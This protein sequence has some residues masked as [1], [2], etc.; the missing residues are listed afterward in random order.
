MRA[1]VLTAPQTIELTT[2]DT[3]EPGP[4]EV[5]VRMRALGLCGSDMGV[6][7]GE[8]PVPS[9]PWVM[10]HEGGGEVVSVGAGVD[11]ARIGQ[12]VVIEPN[13]P[14]LECEACAAGITSVCQNRV[15]VGINAPGLLS[16][17]VAVPTQFAHRLP[18]GMPQEALAVLEPLAVARAAVAMADV[19]AGEHVLVAGAGSQGLMVVQLLRSQGAVPWVMELDPGRLQHAAELG[20]GSAADAAAPAKFAHV[21]DAVGS[22]GLWKALLPK[23]SA[24]TTITV[25][26]MS[27]EPLPVTTKQITRGRMT[28]QGTII[29]DHP[30]D[31]EGTI[32]QASTGELDHA[33]VL[34]PAVPFSR[35]D[36]AFAGATSAPGKTWIVFDGTA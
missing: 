14:C 20:A 3:P 22:P 23:L 16:E 7:T 19:S 15:I 28:I 36:E 21:I 32:A 11:Q 9:F 27:D 35:V 4:G 10:G 17:Y 5:L 33:A 29:Y 31:F 12:T 13:Y 6:Y 26:G 1:A 24:P 2:L 8:R 34:T 18:E 25:I 30:K